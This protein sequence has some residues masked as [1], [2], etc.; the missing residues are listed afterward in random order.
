MFHVKCIQLYTDSDGDLCTIDNNSTL[1]VALKTV[2]SS[3][4]LE[5]RIDHTASS[6]NNLN[7]KVNNDSQS[8]TK[9][10]LRSA[11]IK[12]ETKEIEQEPEVYFY[13]K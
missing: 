12:Q 6:S 5:L 3:S 13:L 10:T 9:R 7:T 1:K 8:T 11:T 2:P 4:T